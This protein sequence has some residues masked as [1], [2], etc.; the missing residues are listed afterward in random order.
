MNKY[1]KRDLAESKRR[2]LWHAAKVPKLCTDC[3]GTGI[4][5]LPEASPGGDPCRHH[6]APTIGQLLGPLQ[7]EF[8]RQMMEKLEELRRV[9]EE[10]HSE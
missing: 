10:D 6:P 1:F 9:R 4:I 7:E 2:P 8:V 5:W 3:N